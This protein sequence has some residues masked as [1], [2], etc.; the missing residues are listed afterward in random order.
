M[1]HILAVSDLHCDFAENKLWVEALQSRPDDCLIVAGDISD[2]L[3][4]LRWTFS[5]LKQKFKEVYYCPGNH[6]LWVPKD[7]SMD[8][9]QKFHEVLRLAEE[10]GLRTK[11]GMFGDV[12]IVPLASWYDE[13]L[14]TAHEF[15]DD[16][17]QLWTDY[18]RCRWPADL[19]TN[20]ARASYF[21]GLAEQSLAS[22]DTSAARILSFSHFFPS[23]EVMDR[24]TE[25]WRKPPGGSQP[26]VKWPNFSAVAGTE[27]LRPLLE[28]LRP[29]IHICGHSHRHFDFLIDGCRHLN[30]PLAYPQERKAGKVQ[31]LTGPTSVMEVP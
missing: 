20:A 7:S 29:A 23:R 4:V 15:L 26:Q 30:L 8:S 18:W 25:T 13:T 3:G 11:P 10:T 1:P 6:E 17:E 22:L 14:Y 12:L 19:A 31:Q 27:R 5:T 28:R 16:N 24:Y 21:V 9:V 2:N